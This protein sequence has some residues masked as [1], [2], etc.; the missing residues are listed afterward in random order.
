MVKE[1]VVK[2]NNQTKNQRS[3]ELNKTRWI[4]FWPDCWAL[5]S[6][7]MLSECPKR[8]CCKWLLPDSCLS[9]Y[10]RQ[11]AAPVAPGVFCALV[12]TLP[13]PMVVS[14]HF[15]CAWFLGCWSARKCAWVR[16]PDSQRKRGKWEEEAYLPA[17]GCILF[18]LVFHCRGHVQVGSEFVQLTRE[19]QGFGEP[20]DSCPLIVSPRGEG[21]GSLAHPTTGWC[22]LGCVGL[23]RGSQESIS[24]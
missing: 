24:Q 5:W 16:T 18:Q 6:A 3:A 4:S 13:P 10:P 20:L 11:R 22:D 12:A 7:D 9:A 23:S 2:T 17:R 19:E 1:V 8:E 21:S 15:H 14:G